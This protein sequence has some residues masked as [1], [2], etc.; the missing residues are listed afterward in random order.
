MTINAINQHRSQIHWGESYSRSTHDEF[1]EPISFTR[2]FTYRRAGCY[3][4]LVMFG[5]D[6]CFCGDYRHKAITV[7]GGIFPN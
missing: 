4:I 5:G 2:E 3:D 7:E 1:E 6:N